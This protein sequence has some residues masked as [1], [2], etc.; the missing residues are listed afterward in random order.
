LPKNAIARNLVA[1]GNARAK[2]L[3][4]SNIRFEEGDASDLVNLEDRG[5]D[6]VVSFFGAMFAPKPGGTIVTGNWI[7]GDQTLVAQIL[8][9]ISAYSPPPP[10][11]SSVQ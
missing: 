3:R 5:L 6:T 2:A 7:P 1:A 8:R 10:K 11:A 4:L 9:I